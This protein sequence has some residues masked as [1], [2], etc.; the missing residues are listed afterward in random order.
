MTD[1]NEEKP[2]TKLDKKTIAILVGFA[3]GLILLIVLNM[4]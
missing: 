4:N 2:P 3:V 1:S